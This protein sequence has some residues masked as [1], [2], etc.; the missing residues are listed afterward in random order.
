VLKRFRI[1]TIADV[2]LVSRLDW[3]RWCAGEKR[4]VM[5]KVAV[6]VLKEKFCKHIFDVY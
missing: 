2:E 4:A 3:A 6:A 5:M 1:A